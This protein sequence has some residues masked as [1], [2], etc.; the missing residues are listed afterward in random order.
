MQLA[1]R[2][3]AYYARFVAPAG[4]AAVILAAL[5]ATMLLAACGGG[6]DGESGTSAAADTGAANVDRPIRLTL[7]EHECAYDGPPVHATGAFAVDLENRSSHFGAFAV[8]ELVQGA[9][10]A[11][12]QAYIAKEQRR[13]DETQELRGPPEFYKQVIR[14]GVPAG[15]VGLLPVDVDPGTYALTCFNDDLP[16]WRGYVAAQLDVTG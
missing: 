8:G 6:D 12:L 7:T 11:D 10:L 13:W 5:A 16:T 2:F 15:D 3:A 14:V 9:T 1:H 4:R